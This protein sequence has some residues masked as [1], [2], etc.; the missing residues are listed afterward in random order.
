MN[1]QL[2]ISAVKKIIAPFKDGLSKTLHIGPIK[3]WA[4]VMHSAFRKLLFAIQF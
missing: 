4:Q 2:Y 1:H 3:L